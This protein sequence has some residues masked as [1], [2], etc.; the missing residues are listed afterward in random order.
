VPGVLS[1]QAIDLLMTIALIHRRYRTMAAK[2]WQN[3]HHL[4]NDAV[5]G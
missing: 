5:C 2:A 4:Y 3:Q 1:T